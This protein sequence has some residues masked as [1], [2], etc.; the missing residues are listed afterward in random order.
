MNLKL[1]R[2]GPWIG[3]AGLCVVLWLVI[4]SLIFFMP[5]WGLIL[6]LIVL[7]LLVRLL[8]SWARTKP[9]RCVWIP[10]L[11]FLAYC[12]VNAIGVLVFGWRVD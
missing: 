10:A 8:R 1:E 11:A 6:H 4:V 12:A 2:S 3:V 7:G 9:A 5:W